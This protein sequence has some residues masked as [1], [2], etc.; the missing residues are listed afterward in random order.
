[1]GGLH[2]ISETMTKGRRA[3]PDIGEG[4]CSNEMASGLGDDTPE[5]ETGVLRRSGG[6]K[7]LGLDD[8]V[9]AFLLGRTERSV[10]GDLASR[11]RAAVH[12]AK[13]DVS[14]MAPDGGT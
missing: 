13:V 3:S 11:R 5:E 14:G 1:M 10:A 8:D 2:L 4:P 6:G 9:F 7:G 12:T